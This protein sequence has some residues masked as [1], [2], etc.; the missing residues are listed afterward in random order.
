MTPKS[1]FLEYLLEML[2]SLGDVRAKSMF[3][4]WG[5]YAG[6]LFFALVANET[7]YLKVDDV[8]RAE[9]ESRAL[10]P[11]RYEANGK[12]SVMSYYPPP[13]EALDDREML[14]TWAC[15]GLAAAERS[16]RAKK[17]RKKK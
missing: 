2:Q 7:L 8:N 11:F 15:K 12:V 6:D 1:E 16:A 9:F 17:P 4:G 14:C 5:V 10:E 3:G 13:A